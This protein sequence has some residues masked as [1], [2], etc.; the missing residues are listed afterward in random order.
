MN[1]S[2][3][4]RTVLTLLY[5]FV[6]GL[7]L[8]YGYK[9]GDDSETKEQPRYLPLFPYKPSLF[10]VV[11]LLTYSI[12]T[13]GSRSISLMLSAMFFSV[14]LHICLYYMLLLPLM[15][16]LRERISAQSCAMLWMIPNFLYIT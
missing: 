5:A 14:F 6:L 7:S 2:L 8:W 4:I 10:I 11:Y 1:K 13:F 12:R 16:F 9:S 3:I 15:P